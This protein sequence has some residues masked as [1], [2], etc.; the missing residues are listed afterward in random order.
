[1]PISRL[2]ECNLTDAMVLKEKYRTEYR[3]W[4]TSTKGLSIK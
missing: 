1:M 3:G 2:I 4:I